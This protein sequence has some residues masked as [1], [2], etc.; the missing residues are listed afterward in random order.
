MFQNIRQRRQI[1]MVGRPFA[2]S[3]ASDR[4]RR[5]KKPL[6]GRNVSPPSQFPVLAL[7]QNQAFNNGICQD[8][9][10]EISFFFANVGL[11]CFK[12]CKKKKAKHSA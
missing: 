5:L 2:L 12:L 10:N 3:G 8:G 6:R 7:F 9:F 4:S 1:G 11:N